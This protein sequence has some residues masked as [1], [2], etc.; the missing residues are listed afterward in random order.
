MPDLDTRPLE[1][2]YLDVYD[3]PAL[4]WRQIGDTVPWGLKVQGW[5]RNQA[6][7][8][9]EARRRYP[10]VRLV[11]CPGVDGVARD[12]RKDRDSSRAVRTLVEIADG[13]VALEIGHL[14]Y[15]PETAWKSEDATE[16]EVLASI[17]H[18][19]MV[20]VRAKH[21]SLTLAI[22]SYGFPARA[23][24]AS[25]GGY[26]GHS[27]FPWRGWLD[28]GV[29]YLGQTY[30][31]PEKLIRY[32]VLAQKSFAEAVTRGMI[33]PGTPRLVEV[34]THGNTP[35]DLVTVG[36]ST[37]ATFFWAAGSSRRFDAQGALGWRACLA[38]W[39]AGCWGEGALAAWQVAHELPS[40]GALTDVTLEVMGLAR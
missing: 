26:G 24:K 6:R 30:D 21:P 4:A 17:A 14:V 10:D 13:C 38:L 19:A 23:T 27:S 15:D 9:E 1:G 32:E 20:A 18:E 11:L 12:W 25:G 2:P 16:R 35:D 3:D 34:Q 31:V 7:A 5:P 33:A 8:I 39:R 28:G 36:T 40:D 22:T 37:P 29:T